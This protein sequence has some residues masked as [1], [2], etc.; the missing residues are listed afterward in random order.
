M[1]TA[2][3]CCVVYGDVINKGNI[4]SFYWQSRDRTWKQTWKSISTPF[5][6][7]YVTFTLRSITR[8]KIFAR[9]YI[10]ALSRNHSCNGNAT[11]LSL[12]IFV[13]V[14]VAVNNIHLYSVG[15]ERQQCNLFLLLLRF[16]KFLTA[17]KNNQYYHPEL[18]SVFFP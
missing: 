9:H 13:S 7:T 18:L 3:L 2:V 15:T 1:L 8:Q 5:M 10:A 6:D 17:F 14:Y 11:I 4:L 16:K 12:P